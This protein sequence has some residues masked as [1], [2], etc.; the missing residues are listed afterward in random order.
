MGPSFL[1]PQ[2]SKDGKPYGPKRFKELV[3]E[4]WYISD[5][6]NTSYTDVL[7]LSVQER[8]YLAECI[9]EKHEATKRA[10]DEIKARQGKK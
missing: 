4:C 2:T 9:K 1:D 6:L 7:D 8:I 5:N 10:F 3:K